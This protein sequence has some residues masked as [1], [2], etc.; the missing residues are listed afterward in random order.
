MILAAQ[1]GSLGRDGDETMIATTNVRHL[2]LF[3]AA[4]IWRD[5]G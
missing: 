3:S 4:R 5:I 2:T 1:A